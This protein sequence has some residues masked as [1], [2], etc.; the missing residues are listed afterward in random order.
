MY[1]SSVMRTSFSGIERFETSKFMK[2]RLLIFP[3]LFIFSHKDPEEEEEEEE[4]LPDAPLRRMLILN[5]PEWGYIFC[6][7]IT[8]TVAICHHF[9]FL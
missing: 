8:C 1:V 2:V 3:S 5:K 4:D 9:S 7:F 6:K